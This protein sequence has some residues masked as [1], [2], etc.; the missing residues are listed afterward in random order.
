MKEMFLRTAQFMGACE[1][2]E[3][4]DAVLAGVPMDFTASFRPGS[5]TAPQEVRN[6]SYV[7]EEYSFYQKKS[8]TDLRYY[9]A[10]DLVL[11]YGNVAESLNL[12]EKA[13]TGFFGSGVFP[14][15]LGGEH[16]ISFPIIKACYERYPDLVVVHFDAHADLRCSYEGEGNSH[17]TVMYKVAEMLG[18]DRLYQFGIRSGTSEEFAY[19]EQHTKIYP[20]EIFPALEGVVE[21]LSGTP[22]YVSLD[23]DAV[24]PAFAPGTGTP[25]PGGCSAREILAAVRAMSSLNVVGMDIVEI[26]PAYDEAQITAVLGAKLVR[27]ALLAFAAKI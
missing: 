22:V 19:A 14:L 10:G 15:F 23:I 2:H 27:E 9:D 6:V 11:P 8:L 24:D 4:V 7:L 12:I 20:D 1:E 26:L 25:E 5:R 16:L 18:K 21:R 3:A 17:A 13:A